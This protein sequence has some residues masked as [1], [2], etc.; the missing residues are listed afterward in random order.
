MAQQQSV[1]AA[2]GSASQHSSPP[3]Y[4]APY[5]G[6]LEGLRFVASLGIV[7][8]HVAFQ[9][10][11]D[12]ATTVGSVLARFDF[13]VAVFYALSAFLLWRA[14]GPG[15]GR[16]ESWAGVGQYFRSR[17]GRIVPAYLALVV[18]VIV[19]LPEATTMTGRQIWANL[20]L[21]QIY[22][23]DGLV[24]GLTHLW[25]L[26]VEVAFYL[27]LPLIVLAVGW[28][29]RRT[30]IGLLVLVAVLSLG[31]AYLPFV[32]ATPAEGVANRQ[33][34]PPAYTCWFVV[35]ILAAEWE[36]KVPVVVQRI[37]RIRWLW[38]LIALAA[39]WVAGQEW[40]GPLGLIHP[41]PDE[42]ARRILAG[43][44]FAFAI[45]VPYAL[46]PVDRVLDS[47]AA[48]T[49]GRWSYS[50]FLWHLPIMALVF[51]LTGI[52]YFSGGFLPVFLLTAV[53]TVVVSAL[54]YEFIEGPGS[55]LIRG[56]RQ[57]SAPTKT[58]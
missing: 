44:V 58:S 31:W 18:A 49:L 20:T 10:G 46:A 34:W 19:L 53:V 22:V 6:S 47:A 28:A 14:Y 33:I 21:T 36:G 56:K 1:A 38:W 32:A 52:G 51:P 55:R 37:F 9:T 2:R 50:V 30:R 7:A 12:P 25:S 13:F 40:F 48:T 42:F 15:T 23:P 8:T 11:V 5:N 26:C 3:Q 43:T 29:G 17:V 4:K 35:G 24:S 54:S 27:A 41:E 45:V 16:L 57:A 39:A